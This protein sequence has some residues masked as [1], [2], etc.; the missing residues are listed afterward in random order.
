MDQMQD[1]YAKPAN[2]HKA[3]RPGVRQIIQTRQCTEDSG[4]GTLFRESLQLKT[5]CMS[6]GRS[7]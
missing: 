3:N 1:S 5:S 7:L 4:Q 2:Q 6:E